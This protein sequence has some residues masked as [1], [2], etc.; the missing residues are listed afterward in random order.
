[1]TTT[2]RFDL[3]DVVHTIRKRRVF[4][5][6]VTLLAAVAGAIFFLVRRPK[7]EAKTEFLV[8]NPLYTDRNSLFRNTEMRFVDNMGGDDDLDKVSAIAESD[9][10]MNIVIHNLHIAQDYNKNPDDPRDMA[11]LRMEFAK[12]LN[13]KRTDNKDAILTY[14]DHD[15]P[16]SAAIANE[17]VRVIGQVFSGTYNTMRHNMYLAIKDKVTDQDSTINSLTDTL[18]ALRDQYGIYAILSPGR[19]NIMTG[20]IKAAGKGAGIGIEKIQNVESIK[21]QMVADRAKYM[22]LMNEFST[23]T[24]VDAVPLTQVITKAKTPLQ[25]KGPGALITILSCALIGFFFS[26]LF[27]LMMAYYRILISVQR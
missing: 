13:F 7:Y 12:R 6:A 20:T 10:V 9:T 11:W 26:S 14:T 25:P 1:M 5:L 8:A 18:A 3:V 4:V 2:P 24:K 22:S 17:M 23:A 16:R 27:V 21:D 19:Q 15:A